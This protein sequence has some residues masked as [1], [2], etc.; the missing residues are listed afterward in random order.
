MAIIAISRG[1]FS[2]GELL[3]K[4]VAERLGY[5]CMSREVLLEAATEYDVPLEDLSAAMERPPSFWERA[6]GERRAHLDFVQAALCEQARGGNLVYHGYVGHLLLPGIAHVISVRAIA[7]A[8]FRIQAVMQERRVG[9]P[10][11]AAYI[12]RVDRER[13]QW[14]RFLFDVAWDDPRLYDLVLH[15][16]R[17]TLATACEMVAQLAARDEFQP[18]GQS[19]RAVRDLALAS[20]VRAVLTRDPLTK[21]ADLHV[22]ASDGAVTVS[23]TALWP[24]LLE[25]IPRVVGEIKGV[26]EVRSELSTVLPMSYYPTP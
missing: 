10:E 23:G 6:T 19:L 2:G 26:R 5:R 24:A 16:G 25:S 14:V 4:A 17:M 9:R 1:T 20:R 12:A 15:L 18:T 8:E 21:D 3:A 7:E 22:A 11:A 13:S